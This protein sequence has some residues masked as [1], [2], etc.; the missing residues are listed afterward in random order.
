MA[1]NYLEKRMEEY[2]AGRLS[3]AYRP[4]QSPSLQKSRLPQ[5]RVFVT[6]GASGIGREIVRAFRQENCQ[7]SFCDIDRKR[8]AE[9]AQSTGA[10]YYYTDVADAVSLTACLDAVLADRG[11]LD[12][13]V[14][15]AG[16]FTTSPIT[17]TTVEDFDRVISV[18]L[19]PVFITARRLAIHRHNLAEPNPYGGRIIN[20]AST[21][22]LMSEASTEPYSASKGG[23]VALTHSLMMSLAEWN[24]TVNAISPGW[25]ET[26]ATA[27]HSEADRLQHP[28]RRVG[29]PADIARLALFLA[30]P[31]NDFINGQNLTVDG[32]MTR[33]M[34]YV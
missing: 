3:R 32:G 4:K 9:T 17:E 21:R 23:I 30:E 28:S 22:A 34:I 24:I 27:V 29:T 6:G 25:I 20:I 11:D 16:I 13:I 26:D 12:V 1:D 2:R 8:G 18:N 19:R 14:N 5:L 33:K 31:A 15:N 10:K 7:V